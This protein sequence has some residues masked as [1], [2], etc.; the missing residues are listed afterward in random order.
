MICDG[1]LVS[2]FARL[3]AAAAWLHRDARVGFEAAF[4]ETTSRGQRIFGSTSAMEGTEIWTVSYAIEVDGT[5]RTRSARVT[6][7][8]A[9]GVRETAIRGDGVGHW[10]VDDQVAPHLEGCLDVDLESSAMTN[11]L[12]VHRMRLG[13]GARSPA[14]AAY[15]RCLDLS[16]ERLEQEYERA[17]D[18][19]AHQRYDYASPGFDFYGRL[20]YDASGLVLDYPGIAVRVG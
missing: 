20:V 13:P 15:V 12:P 6:G 2:P 16:V 19:G 9:T 3:P 8:S 1:R 7:R 10:L 5:W 11:A 17:T 4:F 14:P 18:D